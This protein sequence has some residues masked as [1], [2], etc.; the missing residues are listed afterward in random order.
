MPQN[1]CSLFVEMGTELTLLACLSTPGCGVAL[2]SL[3]WRETACKGSVQSLRTSPSFY[4][5]GN[6]LKDGR[7]EAL[8]SPQQAAA[9][10]AI[11]GR[12]RLEGPWEVSGPTSCSLQGQLW[13]Q[14]KLLRDVSS[15]LLEASEE[16][17]CAASTGNLLHCPHGGKVSHLV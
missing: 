9:W 2:G 12:F 11:A 6:F 4:H 5:G 3:Q 7:A 17:T 15:W 14:T 13:G 8:A 10:S 16:V 1:W